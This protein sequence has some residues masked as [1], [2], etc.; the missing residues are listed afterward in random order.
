MEIEFGNLPHK[1]LVQRGKPHRWFSIDYVGEIF[2]ARKEHG[3]VI[4][5]LL[6]L[7]VGG[8]LVW[9]RARLILLKLWKVRGQDL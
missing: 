6:D 1:F 5:P 7:T 4:G 3:D 2:G 9:P 8:Q